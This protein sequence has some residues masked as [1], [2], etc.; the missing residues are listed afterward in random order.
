MLVATDV[1]ARG[2]DVDDVTHVFNFQ[3]PED[4]KTYLHRVG[5]TG[6]AGN[7]GTAVTL[8]DWEDMPRWSLIN[9]ALGLNVPEPPETY[10]SSP[11]LFEDLNIPQGTKGRLPTSQRTHAGLD[12]EKLEDLGGPESKN[13]RDSRGG[14]GGRDGGRGR[15]RDAEPGGREGGRTRSRRRSGGSGEAHSQDQAQDQ[16]QALHDDGRAPEQGER[17]SRGGG[18]QPERNG[19]GSGSGERRRRSRSRSRTRRRDGEVV[20]EQRS[21]E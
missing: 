14:R 19:E 18:T 7:K 2:I 17:A 3:C 5:R 13:R 6:R 15:S 21:A 12:A 9:K 20:Q 10:S 8:V 4:E 16:K 11:S 1:A